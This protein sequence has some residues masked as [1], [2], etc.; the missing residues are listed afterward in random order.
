MQQISLSVFNHI[1]EK[2]TVLLRSLLD[3]FEREQ[4]IHVDFEVIDWRAGWARLVEMA[5]YG[6]G[7]DI[8]EVGS[9]WIVDLMRMNA[10]QSLSPR[11]MNPIGGESDFMP[12]NWKAG[13]TLNTSDG[14]PIVWG[15]PWSTDVRLIFYRRDFLE[16]AKID[17]TLAF[18][19]IQDLAQTIESLKAHG[20]Q[21]PVSLATLRSPINV[22][23]MASWIWDCG[24]D[25]MLPNSKRVAFDNPKAL[26]GMRYYF[27]MGQYI[28]PSHHKISEL[29][30]DR[31]FTSEDAALLFSG[32]WL[33]GTPE[34]KSV[35]ANIGLASMP[36]GSFVGGSHLVMWKHTKKRE[37]A[38]LLLDFMVKHSMEHEIFPTYGLPTYLRDWTATPFM[39][40]PY[41]SAFRNALQGGRSFPANELWG[42]VE[43]R[44][45]DTVPSI[46]EKVLDSEKPDIE[47]IVADTMIPLARMLNLSLEG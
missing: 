32:S 29:D 9:T 23:L 28:P 39:E 26:Q 17:P 3:A 36:G 10:L 27:G 47:K 42:L 8:S 5:I 7:P 21:L 30:V 43:K 18:S 22:H 31:L 35:E 2:Q 37:A 45:A 34:I 16:K 38:L 12:A 6:R 19:H 13:V 46:W 40:E 44:L 14:S 4:N 24:G 15:V 41:F 20:F 1:A 11:D 25:F 33:I